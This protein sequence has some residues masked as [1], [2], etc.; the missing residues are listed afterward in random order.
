MPI[1]EPPEVERVLNSFPPFHLSCPSWTDR[2]LVDRPAFKNAYRF[3]ARFGGQG[4]TEGLFY[5]PGGIVI[6]NVG[7][8]FIADS[9]NSRVQ[10]FNTKGMLQKIIGS[11]RGTADGQF[12]NPVGVAIDLEDNLFVTDNGNDRIQVFN[13]DSQFTLKFGE[14]I[15]KNPGPLAIDF[16]GNVAVS[17]L[18]NTRIHVFNSTGTW[19]RKIDRN[20]SFIGL[21]FD[22]QCNLIVCE[23]PEKVDV[24]DPM[25]GQSK[26]LIGNYWSSDGEYLSHRRP[27]NVIVDKKGSV[28]VV[29]SS[30]KR[31]GI[32]SCEGDLLMNIDLICRGF[33][34]NVPFGVA[35]DKQ[36]TLYVTDIKAN[37]IH[38]YG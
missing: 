13:A 16:D 22:L 36:G 28:A 24:I 7:L 8:I 17:D 32:F 26:R 10:V 4:T 30:Q 6:N 20:G 31:M 29:E 21:T 18:F 9:G 25:T 35:M 34:Q 3:Q 37:E 27:S 38:I 15:L 14:H 1:C 5:R 33:A 23:R 2:F 11:T 12:F 19:L